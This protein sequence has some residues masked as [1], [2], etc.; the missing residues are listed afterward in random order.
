MVAQKE[1]IRNRTVNPGDVIH[2]SQ[3]LEEKAKQLAVDAPDI[4]GDHIQVPTYFIVEYP[5]GERQALH[6]VKD[7]KK[8]SD[9]IRQAQLYSSD[10][11]SETGEEHFINWTGIVLIIALFLI[12]V[13]ILLGIF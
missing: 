1:K 6:H 2:E 11:S 4:A 8:I 5:N 9:I 3:S 7:A 13:P 10:S 12:T